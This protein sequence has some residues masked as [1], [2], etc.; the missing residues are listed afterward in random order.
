M[1][2]AELQAAVE[3]NADLRERLTEAFND[4]ARAMGWIEKTPTGPTIRDDS[5]EAAFEF[6]MGA[7]AFATATDNNHFAG[8]ELFIASVRGSDFV[9]PLHR[10][11]RSKFL[12]AREAGK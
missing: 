4:R 7:V 2:E 5:R 9:F 3:A 10:F 11:D 8:P 1:T 6:L 12:A